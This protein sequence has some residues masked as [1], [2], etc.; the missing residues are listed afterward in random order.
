[1]E[2]LKKWDKK[3]LPHNELAERTILS[4]VITSTDAL[5]IVLQALKVKTFYFK[6]HQEI[7]RTI[8]EM[9]QKNIPIDVL[10]LN[11]YLQDNGYLE[12]IGGIDF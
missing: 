10:T 11:T 12:N 2:D 8:I 3:P 9:N 1:M 6:S 7:Y 5:E 4:A